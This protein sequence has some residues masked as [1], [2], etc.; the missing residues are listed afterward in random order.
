ML[1]SRPQ[2]SG[3]QTVHARRQAGASVDRRRPARRGRRGDGRRCDHRRPH[4]PIKLSRIPVL[5]LPT[6]PAAWR[7]EAD[8]FF[9]RAPPFGFACAQRF[10]ECMT[11]MSAVRP[12]PWQTRQVSLAPSAALRAA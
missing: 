11:A 2:S 10:F 7:A 12:V 1:A 3:Q 9:L 4:H 8:V 5:L 6:G